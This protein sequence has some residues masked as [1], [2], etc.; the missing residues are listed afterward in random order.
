MWLPKWLRIWLEV[1]RAIAAGF[2]ALMARLDDIALKLVTPRPG[3]FVA[4]LVEAERMAPDGT[5]VPTTFGMTGRLGR[6]GRLNMQEIAQFPLR[7]GRVVV[8]CD[9]ELVEVPGVFIGHDFMHC[10]IGSCPVAFFVR[11]ELGQMIRVQAQRRPE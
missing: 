7:N 6:D 8:F 4:V 9:L 1:P 11:C 3:P 5:A 2:S 10:A